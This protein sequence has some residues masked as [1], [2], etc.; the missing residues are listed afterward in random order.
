[1]EW[2]L[3]QSTAKEKAVIK[4]QLKASADQVAQSPGTGLVA[5]M[6]KGPLLTGTLLTHASE[7][8]NAEVRC[9]ARKWEKGDSF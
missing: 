9:A 2:L 4:K 5:R 1:M 8:K 3:D 7:A 6:R